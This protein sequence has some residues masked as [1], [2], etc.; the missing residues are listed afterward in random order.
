MNILNKKPG[1]F[2]FLDENMEMH[3]FKDYDDVPK[4]LDIYNVI[5]FLPDVPLPPHS[6]QD[7]ELMNSWN[8]ELIR[9]MEEIKNGGYG[10][11]TS[12]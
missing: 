10:R 5:C 4:D 1:T 8:G 12:S 9:L 6:V 2:I 7:H 3:R 11:T